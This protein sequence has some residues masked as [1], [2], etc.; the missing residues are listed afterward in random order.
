MDACYTLGHSLEK[1]TGANAPATAW[2]DEQT[3][4]H[5]KDLF[6]LEADRKHFQTGFYLRVK[7]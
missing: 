6:F 5:S 2:N 3:Q 1:H 4:I 7:T